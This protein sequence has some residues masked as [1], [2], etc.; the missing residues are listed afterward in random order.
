MQTT[1]RLRRRGVIEML[2]C[3]ALWSIAGIFIKLIP[4]NAFLIAGIR[5]LIAGLAVF[6]YM[7]LRRIALRLDRQSITGG[8]ALCLT[9]ICFVGANKLTAAANAIVLQFTAPVFLM[10]FSALKLGR[11][12]SGADKAAVAVTLGGIALFFFD[13]LDA[14]RLSGNIV[15]ILAGLTLGRYYMSLDGA[16]MNQRMSAILLG[17]ALCALSAIPFLIIAPP[18]LNFASVWHILVLGVFQLGLPYI[19]LAHASEYCPP[20]ACCLLGAV[21]PILNPVWVLIFDG[22][23]PGGFALIGGVIVIAAVTAWSIYDGR[24]GAAEVEKCPTS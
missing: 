5:S 20:L 1:A 9:F 11:R 3:A 10:A 19:L 13:H 24:R 23:R 22:E 8:I 15:G 17:N 12:F 4:W 16:D 18:E 21:E 14:G 7:R 2:T 6:I